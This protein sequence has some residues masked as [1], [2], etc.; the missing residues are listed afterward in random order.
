MTDTLTGDVIDN[1]L[2]LGPSDELFRLREQRAKMK[3]LT[4]T[5]YIAA[6]RPTEA[7]N[8]SYAMRAAIAARMSSLWKAD[9]LRAHYLTALEAENAA[10]DV[11]AIADPASTTPS[12][13]RLAAILAHVDIVTLS[14][15]EATR[16]NIDRL[17]AV[18][19]DDRDIVTLAGLIA[20]VN[21]Q[22]LVVAGLKMMRDN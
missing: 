13:Q 16:A 15:K 18:G 6:L 12:D 14:P 19:L 10:E 21:Y 9:E 4:Q 2:G 7:R 1:V 20:Y 8:F 3:H 5:S 22:I 17:Y 11:V